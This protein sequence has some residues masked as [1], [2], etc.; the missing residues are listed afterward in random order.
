MQGTGAHLRHRGNLLFHEPGL[1]WSRLI[2]SLEIIVES[3]IFHRLHD[4]TEA[5]G[6][7]QLLCEMKLFGY[8]ICL[9]I[10]HSLFIQ[11]MFIDTNRYWFSHRRIKIIQT[12]VEFQFPIRG[13]RL[14]RRS[15]FPSPPL[16][17]LSPPHF[18]LYLS[19]PWR[20]GIY[21]PTCWTSGEH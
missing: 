4:T 1:W 15:S 17:F 6:S 2:Q 20:I 8:G 3:V 10:F 21:A 9:I 11:L 18:P 7:S 13:D 12:C 14:P 5:R 19:L 16:L